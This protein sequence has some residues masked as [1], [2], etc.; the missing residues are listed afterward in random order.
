MPESLLGLA[1]ARDR[2]RPGLRSDRG[3]PNVLCLPPEDATRKLGFAGKPY[4]HVDVASVDPER[5]LE[6]RRAASSSCAARTCS[7]GY[8]RNPEATAAAFRGRLAA[9]RRPRRAGRRGL[10]PI[11]G[12]LKEPRHLR[13]RERPSGR[14][15]G[16]SARPPAVAEAAVVGP[17]ERWGEV[18]VAFVVLRRGAPMRTSCS[19]GAESGS[20]A[21]RCRRRSASSSELPRSAKGK[22]LKD[23]LLEPAT[24]AVRDRG[25]DHRGRGRRSSKR[26]A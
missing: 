23:E 8:W 14:D 26:G 19:S 21:T 15:R 2:D 25:S 9:H 20:P 1:R 11:V 18:C 3:G 12:R 13:R 10:L 17:D 6:G 16:R 4:P 24:E 5:Y 7:A 22:V